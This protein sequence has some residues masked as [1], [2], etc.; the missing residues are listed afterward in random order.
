MTNGQLLAG[1]AGALAFLLAPLPGAASTPAGVSD[2]VGSSA[3]AGEQAL[4]SRGYHRVSMSPGD[5]RV[6]SYWW[7]GARNDCLSVVSSDGRLAQMASV[8]SADCH[9]GDSSSGTAQPASSGSGSN[10]AAA[11]AVVGAAALIG[12]VALAHNSHHHKDKKHYDDQQSESDYER[13]YRDGLYSTGYHNYAR[14]DAY[15][16]GYESGS[17]Q[18]G[19]ETSYKSGYHSG[20]GYSRY[21]SYDDLLYQDKDRARRDL[22]HR[23]FDLRDSYRNDADHRVEI[24]WNRSTEQCVSM[25]VRKGRVDDIHSTPKRNC[26]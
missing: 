13:G 5:D 6:Y 2:L 16:D 23:G 26:R 1:A 24:Y 20:G 25:T 4:Q 11:A 14:N 7:N 17:R 21:A 19:Y 22:E 12:A 9:Q 3:Y 18:R 15:S 10:P 8:A